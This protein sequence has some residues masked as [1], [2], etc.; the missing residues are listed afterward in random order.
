M[1]ALAGCKVVLIDDEPGVL[2][3]LTLLLQTMGCAVMA[4][5][6]PTEALA[7]LRAGIECDLIL[8][9]QRM[10]GLIGSE[11]FKLLRAHSVNAPF[12]LMSGHAGESEVEDV[13]RAPN[14]AFLTKPFSPVSLQSAAVAAI[15]RPAR[16]RAV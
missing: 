12:V 8:S 9:D 7:Y 3:A 1:S 6:G 4:F 13:L 2:K 5:G 16:A 15:G 11:L 14:T 10:P